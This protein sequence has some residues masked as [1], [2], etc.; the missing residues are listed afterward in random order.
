[1]KRLT[2]GTR[3]FIGFGVAVFLCIVTTVVGIYA[4]SD[5]GKQLAEV[6][7]V[8]K[9]VD[10]ISRAANYILDINGSTRSIAL[11]ET[12]EERNQQLQ[13][14][15]DLRKKYKQEMEMLTANLTTPEGKKLV[16]NLK[17]SIMA[18]KDSNNRALGFA[19]KGDRANFLPAYDETKRLT[20]T[21]Y[22]NCQKLQDYCSAYALKCNADAAR[23]GRQAEIA[24]AAFGLLASIV[25]I[26]IS[27]VF[28]KG[29]TR[30]IHRCID[31]ANKAAE[32]DLTVE[33]D[34]DGKDETAQLMSA[35]QQM[36]NN[37][38]DIIR[39][40]AEISNG[41]ASASN[42]LHVTSTQIA[43]GA[44][45][46]ASQTSTVAT[47]SEEMSSTSN[48]IARSCTFAAEASTRTTDS[49]NAGALVVQET[50]NGMNAIATR[51]RQTS[52]TIE[53]L[54]LRSDQIGAIVNTIE[55]IADQT[56]LL[57]LNA[58]IEAARAGEQGRGFAVVADEVRALAER[59]TKATREIGEM[60]KAIQNETRA[61]VKEMEEGVHEVE[62]G[63]VSSE[64][65]GQ[66]LEEI[67]RRIAEVAMQISGIATAAEEQTATTC[68]VAGNIQQITDVVNEAAVGAE[69]TADAAAGLAGRASELQNLVGRFKVA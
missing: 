32:G 27:V 46:I 9:L 6:E 31:V 22:E 54:G 59:T 28:T 18:G 57:A 40:T 4:V 38:R 51:V 69:Q 7:R 53:A 41:I 65:S 29:I 37:L 21:V 68:D 64:K 39:Q 19:M 34:C 24:L 63:A 47:A 66:A 67:L 61:A 12:A 11:A 60:I 8:H 36:V 56:N 52:R 3:L 50:M 23:S 30:P 16:Q 33:I 44:Q 13:R 17:D 26:I 42:Q 43:T 58:A 1:M 25:C 15:Q 55:D 2:I 48:D 45:T 35:M 62:K 14:V 5:I 10:G 49:A 20:V